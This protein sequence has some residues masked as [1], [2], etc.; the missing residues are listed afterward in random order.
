MLI[1]TSARRFILQWEFTLAKPEENL[2]KLFAL[3]GNGFIVCDFDYVLTESEMNCVY[4]SW[5]EL[6]ILELKSTAC[7]YQKLVSNKLSNNN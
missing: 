3:T 5:I 7:I 2:V 1:Y 4:L 6:C